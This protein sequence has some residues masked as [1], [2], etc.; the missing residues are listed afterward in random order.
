MQVGEVQAVSS[1]GPC[2]YPA[3]SLLAVLGGVHVEG[4]Q[5]NTWKARVWRQGGSGR[6]APAKE[7]EKHRSD[8]AGH[9]AT[10]C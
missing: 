8:V 1:G 9:T 6:R 10:E 3:S 2:K 4:R 5:D 7:F